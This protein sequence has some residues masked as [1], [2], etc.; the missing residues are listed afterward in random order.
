MAVWLLY[1]SYKC[2]A[3]KH[4]GQSMHPLYNFSLEIASVTF[5]SGVCGKVEKVVWLSEN[6]SG[7]IEKAGWKYDEP[8]Q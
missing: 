6:K 5:L 2:A 4:V 8:Q 3:V 1:G 7:R